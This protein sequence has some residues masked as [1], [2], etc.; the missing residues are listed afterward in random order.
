[1]A[2]EGEPGQERKNEQQDPAA[3]ETLTEGGDDDQQRRRE[4]ERL[5]SCGE[6]DRAGRRDDG[7]A[8]NEVPDDREQGGHDHGDSELPCH[9]PRVQ[10]RREGSEQ[11]VVDD[12]ELTCPRRVG[13]VRVQGDPG[14]GRQ[15][16]EDRD[17]ERKS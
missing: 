5:R 9:P 14:D 2:H 6:A 1:V 12:R 13:D 3:D 4:T 7:V 11:R 15:P 8:L 10:R 17:G 16:E